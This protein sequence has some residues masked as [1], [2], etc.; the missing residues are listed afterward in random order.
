[1]GY[2]KKA[3]AHRVFIPTSRKVVISRYVQFI[4][5]EVCNWED[6]VVP[7]K[8]LVLQKMRTSLPGNLHSGD[9]HTISVIES[10][11]ESSERRGLFLIRQVT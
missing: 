7:K 3:K 9:N 4:E 2:S 6:T 10:A 11:G 5:N 8:K 1:M